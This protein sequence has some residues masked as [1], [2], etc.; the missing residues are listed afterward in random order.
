LNNVLLFLLTTPLTVLLLYAVKAPLFRLALTC[1]ALPWYI[2]LVVTDLGPPLIKVFGKASGPRPLT[3]EET[4]M[5]DRRGTREA[6]QT[7][8]TNPPSLIKVNVSKSLQSFVDYSWR[9]YRN[10]RYI[11]LLGQGALQL[12][13]GHK[14]K[15]LEAVVLSS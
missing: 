3:Q 11:S 4:L 13:S 14:A 10:I 12:L 15:G 2:H 8:Q 6:P 9:C 7:R 1:L 5:P